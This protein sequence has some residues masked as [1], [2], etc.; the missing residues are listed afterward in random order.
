MPRFLDP[1]DRVRNA[2]GFLS[3]GAS[4]LPAERDDIAHALTSLTED[5]PGLQTLSWADLIETLVTEG[6]E[7]EL[8]TPTVHEDL[9]RRVDA[10]RKRASRTWCKPPPPERELPRLL[11]T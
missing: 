6:D 10:A 3:R 5:R 1:E 9:L 4:D 2:A 11:A 8:W 7:L